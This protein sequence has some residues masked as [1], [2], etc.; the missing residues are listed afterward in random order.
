MKKDMGIYIHI[1]FCAQKCTYCDFVSYA[2]KQTMWKPYIQWLL[3]EI[4]Q[5]GE[6]N[7][8]DA[9]EGLDAKIGVK[10]I[11]IGGGTP[12]ILP[13]E[14]IENIIKTVYTYLEVD[15]DA[16]ITIEV[17]PG[18]VTEEKLQRYRKAGINRIS[19][20][21]QAMQ[22]HL[23]Q[24]LGRIHTKQQAIQ[25]Y[26]LARK[27]GFENCNID[28]MLGL[29][30]QT[31]EDI[32]ETV[33]EIL[34]LAP[35][36]ISMYSLI[37]EEGTLLEKQIEEGNLVLPT[38]EIERNMYWKV[39]K[40]LEEAGY[41][42]YEISN[43]AKP[44]KQS[45]HNLDCWNQKEYIGF[46]VGAHSY[47]NGIRYSNIDSVEDYIAHYEAD[48]WQDN[49]IF[50]EK[51]NTQSMQKE[52]ML[53]GFRKLDG[54]SISEFKCK[55]VDNPCYVFRK[56]LDKLCKE[57]L[58]IIEDEDTIKLTKKGLDVANLVFEEFV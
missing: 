20:G 34:T 4:K 15:K 9:K 35:E 57:E 48:K 33:K 39:K 31:M 56:E 58:V 16:E 49:L 21:M 1:P 41:I 7:A 52:Y 37:V 19:I 26:E 6:G 36:H 5:V 43:F 55:F 32:Q 50:H 12:S 8:F 54:I 3:E 38:E 51:Q 30:Q 24:M 23:L 14:D 29:P 25:T 47:T 10:T 44:G 28:M 42:H 46:G 11:Y 53:L 2:C 13:P 22:P 45:K 18:T 40:L 17:N 27:A